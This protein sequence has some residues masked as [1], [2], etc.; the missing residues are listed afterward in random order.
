MKVKID[1][2]HIHPF[3]HTL[4]EI[5]HE[6]KGFAKKLF[7]YTQSA[8]GKEGADYSYLHLENRECRQ[9]GGELEQDRQLKSTPRK[10]DKMTF[11]EIKLLL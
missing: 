7:F 8:H 10:D 6:N 2:E 4:S 5:L 11:L 1:P 3:A 9:H